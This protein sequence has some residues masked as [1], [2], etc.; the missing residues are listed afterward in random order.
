MISMFSANAATLLLAITQCAFVLVTNHYLAQTGRAPYILGSVAL[1]IAI[2]Y[3]NR[4]NQPLKASSKLLPSV[5]YVLGA[6][7]LGVFVIGSFSEL[8]EKVDPA[9]YAGGPLRVIGNINPDDPLSFLI[10]LR[11][12]VF[13]PIVEEVVSRLGILGSIRRM[14]GKP[15]V[16]LMVS[17]AIFSAM[18]IQG[19]V[20]L[21]GLI[22][23]FVIGLTLGLT[24]LTLGLPWAILLHA[25]TNLMPRLENA[26][27][28]DN[29]D[30]LWVTLVVVAVVGVWIFV[31]RSAR[32]FIRGTPATS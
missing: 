2:L 25:I 14:T 16:A 10:L 17:S 32:F 11:S 31:T 12:V 6:W 26:G 22:P 4:G 23:L 3:I 29:H 27:A 13:T 24:Y 8:L 7:L 9:K 15:L 18:H 20:S 30:A 5:L 28:L 21:M 19:V 1:V